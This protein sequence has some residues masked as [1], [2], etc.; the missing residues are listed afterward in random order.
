MSTLS[1]LTLSALTVSVV[2][3]GVDYAASSHQQAVVASALKLVGFDIKQ[4]LQQD[5][6]VLIVCVRWSFIDS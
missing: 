4:A 3:P 6:R 1:M 5:G 2:T